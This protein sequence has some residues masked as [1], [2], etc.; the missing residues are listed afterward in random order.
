MLS[1]L[2]QWLN[3]N[4]YAVLGLDIGS[5]S[6]KLIQLEHNAG[7][8][9]VTAAASEDIDV[10][11]HIADHVDEFAI[12]RAIAQCIEQSGCS[13]KMA[14]CGVSGSQVAVRDFQFPALAPAEL[15]GAIRLEASQVCPFSVDEGA[16]DYQLLA[17][18]NDRVKGFLVA[19]TNKVIQSKV[20]LASDATLNTVLMEVD[21][22][23]LLNVLREIEV[24][25]PSRTAAVLN[26]GHTTTN[27]AVIG[28]DGIPF[29]RDIHHAGVEISRKLAGALGRTPDDAD[30]LVKNGDFE[31][32]AEMLEQPARELMNDINNSLRYYQAQGQKPAIETIYVCGGFS[33]VP[34]FVSL[35]ERKLGADVLQWNPFD[36]MAKAV[37]VET[38]SLLATNGPAMAVAAGLA[39]RSI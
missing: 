10:S 22:L 25:D 34:G 38:E 21:G 29:I 28:N 30:A 16:V 33:I 18:D 6:V 23:A 26:V 7:T 9:T 31:I 5:A 14:V 13:A 20:L 17:K 15:A 1:K 36:K 2:K 12:G 37:P 19:A 32:T 35:L 4:Q 11:R 8:W 27:L 3:I 24:V 39:M